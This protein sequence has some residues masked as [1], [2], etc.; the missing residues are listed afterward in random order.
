MASSLDHL[1]SGSSARPFQLGFSASLFL[2]QWLLRAER[3]AAPSCATGAS[4]AQ[5]QCE[6][7]TEVWRRVKWNG[8]E[9][10]KKKMKMEMEMNMEMEM[11]MRVR[12]EQNCSGNGGTRIGWRA[13]KQLECCRL[14][15]VQTVSG[16]EKEQ[17]SS[18]RFICAQKAHKMPI[19][20]AQKPHGKRTRHS[21]ALWRHC[22][23][24]ASRQQ[25]FAQRRALNCTTLLAW[26]PFAPI[27]APVLARARVWSPVGALWLELAASCTWRAAP[28]VQPAG[29]FVI[30]AISFFRRDL[31]LIWRPD[32]V[33][34]RS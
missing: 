14:C 3:L 11:E 23:P 8:N 6:M 4:S 10:K 27:C 9:K 5:Q 34:Q 7:E 2:G 25:V 32:K 33:G 31:P 28:R 30:V 29:S 15:A 20:S 21:L 17:W 22:G 24:L 18:A 1:Q 26:R 16:A 12:M 13:R 19:E